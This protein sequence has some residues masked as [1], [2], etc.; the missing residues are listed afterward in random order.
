VDEKRRV[1]RFCDIRCG[2]QKDSRY[3]STVI[4]NNRQAGDAGVLSTQPLWGR[5]AMTSRCGM[6]G[7]LIVFSCQRTHRSRD[8]A[9]GL[10]S[11]EIE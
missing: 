8:T 5:V 4:F 1:V 6:L 10:R 11:I 3:A 9:Q 2:Y 7:I